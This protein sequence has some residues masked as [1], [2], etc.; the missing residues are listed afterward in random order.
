MF[1]GLAWRKPNK[2]D[3]FAKLGND[4]ANI[5]GTLNV[6]LK[7]STLSLSQKF[8]EF[9]FHPVVHFYSAHWF[10]YRSFC[11]A[12]LLNKLQMF[13]EFLLWEVFGD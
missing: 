10:W 6:N 4:F 11:F 3:I 12:Y 13:F 5:N 7:S 2:W 9:G 1:E 8:S